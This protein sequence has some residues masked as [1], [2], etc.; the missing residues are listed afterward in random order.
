MGVECPHTS[1]TRLL[2]RPLALG[3]DRFPVGYFTPVDPQAEPQLGL[4]HTHAFQTT[5]RPL[6]SIIAERNQQPLHTLLTTRK[7]E[8][9]LPAPASWL[10]SRT[11]QSCDPRRLASALSCGSGQTV[12]RGWGGPQ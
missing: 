7:N 9:Y 5:A 2:G 10:I 4:V 12:E 3:L 8:I 11:P 6:S 1:P